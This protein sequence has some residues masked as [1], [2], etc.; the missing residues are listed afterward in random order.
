MGGRGEMGCGNSKS[1]PKSK[2]TED[3]NTCRLETDSLRIEHQLQ[4]RNRS[5]CFESVLLH[6]LEMVFFGTP[7]IYLP[8]VCLP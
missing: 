4:C 7:S 3:Q 6:H 8:V 1:G 5:N 2:V